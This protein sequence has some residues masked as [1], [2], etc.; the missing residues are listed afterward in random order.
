[1]DT[2][3]EQNERAR[4][5]EA[6]EYLRALGFVALGGWLFRHSSGTTYDLSAADLSKIDDIV[7]KRLFV[8][9]R[10]NDETADLLLDACE[11]A[12]HTLSCICNALG[13]MTASSDVESLNKLESAIRA[14]GGKA[15]DF[16]GK[17]RACQSTSET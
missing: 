12:Y 4:R 10:A 14:A 6:I 17:D 2:Y 16:N 8:V 11:C 13:E 15:I 1:M 7:N 5:W 9:H 3:D